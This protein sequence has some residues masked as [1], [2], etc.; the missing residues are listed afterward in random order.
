V[1]ALEDEPEKGHRLAIL[2]AGAV[3][4]AALQGG[5]LYAASK[6]EPPPKK[7]NERIEVAIVQKAKPP[8]PPPPPKEEI[9]EQPKPPEPPKPEP[10]KPKPKIEKPKP[11]P[12]PE[13]PK[14]EPPPPEPPKPPP[15]LVTG[16]T[17]ESTVQAGK[18]PAVQVGNTMMGAVAT[19]AVAPVTKPGV[20]GGTGDGPIVSQGS[21]GGVRTDAVEKNIVKPRYTEMARNQGIE[22]V[23]QLL[24]TI[25]AEGRVIEV[26]VLK[27]LGFGLDE[28][29]VTAARQWK[30]EPARVDGKGI[31]TKITRRV[32]FTLDDF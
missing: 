1:H 26:K 5:G 3:I 9:V 31:Q 8:P 6:Y 22:G 10:P 27:G 2:L 18:G 21:Q 28:A 7:K 23:V 14:P 29:A 25:D 32:R 4:A 11:P 24:L 30:F 12:P 19:T 13:P 16:L 15:P 17:L 20:K